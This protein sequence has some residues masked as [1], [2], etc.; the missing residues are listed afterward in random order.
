MRHLKGMIVDIFWG[1]GW[2]LWSRNE[3]E[4][5]APDKP[6]FHHVG[7]LKLPFYIRKEAEKYLNG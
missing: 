3:I 7:G 6:Y 5:K 4:F 2:D 1:N